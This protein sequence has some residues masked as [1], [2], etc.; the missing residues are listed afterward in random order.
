[1]NFKG[2]A[3]L[4]ALVICLSS[5]SFTKKTQHVLVFSATKGF[6][7]S[8]IKDGKIALLKMG[9][10]QGFAVDTTED[11]KSFDAQNLKKYRTVILLSPT[12]TNV[13][14]DEQKKAFKDFVN[15]GG[16]VVGIHAAADFCY[17]WEWYNKMIGAYF[18]SHP[19]IQEAK[20]IAPVPASKLLKGV[21]SPWMHKDE[22]Y[23]YKSLN[24]AI[25]VLLKLDETSYKGGN[26]KE[27]HPIAWYH[28]F[29]GGKVFYTG[30]GHTSE[31][32]TDPVFLTHIANALK[33]A[34]K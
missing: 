25:K 34:M 15:N 31:C 3:A 12:G 11:A 30:L 10:E 33:W 7:H 27:N 23:N 17:E 8:S 2:F 28:E 9:K 1:M 21:S 4:L 5:F 19:A 13:F 14:S 18:Q 20:L 29:E 6:R 16:S 24:P 22:W 26:M 32:Y